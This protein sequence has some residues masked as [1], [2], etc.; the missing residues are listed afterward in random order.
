VMGREKSS[1]VDSICVTLHPDEST[2]TVAT[3]SR[4]V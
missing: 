1:A 2:M 3:E 4:E